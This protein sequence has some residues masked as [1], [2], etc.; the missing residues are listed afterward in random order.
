MVAAMFITNNYIF[1][2]ETYNDRTAVTMLIV[3]NILSF[4][5][6]TVAHFVIGFIVSSKKQ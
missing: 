4:V 5:A 2:E 1:P 3:F 6:L